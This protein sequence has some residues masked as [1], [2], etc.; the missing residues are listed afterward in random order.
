MEDK[1]LLYLKTPISCYALIPKVH[2]PPLEPKNFLVRMSPEKVK[3]HEKEL[4]DTKVSCVTTKTGAKF[5]IFKF[6]EPKTNREV[7]LE[8]MQMAHPICKLVKMVKEEL[9]EEQAIRKCVEEGKDAYL[10][11]KCKPEGVYG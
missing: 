4:I 11:V 6:K 2:R 9:T 1:A 8:G 7:E 5:C 10:I 3:E